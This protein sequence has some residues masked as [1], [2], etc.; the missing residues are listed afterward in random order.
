MIN[1]EWE[2]GFFGYLPVALG[3]LLMKFPKN[4][5]TWD[6]AEIRNIPDP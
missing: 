5:H 2:N 3:L 1:S 6:M 4:Y